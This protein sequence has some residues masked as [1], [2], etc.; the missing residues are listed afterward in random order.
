MNR[1]HRICL[2]LAASAGLLLATTG[3][4]RAGDWPGWR[5]PTGMGYATDKD[6]PHTWGG[7]NQENVIWKVPLFPGQEKAKQD[8][9]QS[10]P[11]VA[12]GRV[13]VTVAYW[14]AGVSQKESPEHHVLCSDTAA[15]NL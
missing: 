1:V 5:G 4:S 2:V 12:G 3:I 6:L 14:P 8:H 13:F 15:D 10:S 11:I 7:K 9:N